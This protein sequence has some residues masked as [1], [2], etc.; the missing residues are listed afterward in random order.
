MSPAALKTLMTGLA[1][2]VSGAAFI[3]TIPLPVRGFLLWAAG[4]LKGG[5]LIPQP[6]TAQD[7]AARLAKTTE[8]E[9]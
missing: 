2:V 9:K 8:A 5:A 7:L 4:M 1:L 3:P 6:S